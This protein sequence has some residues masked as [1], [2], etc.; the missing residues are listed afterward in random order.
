MSKPHS[1][2]SGFRGG[3]QN[4]GTVKQKLLA[5]GWT[6]QFEVKKDM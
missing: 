1:N 4:Q 5:I 6:V 2:N 3:P